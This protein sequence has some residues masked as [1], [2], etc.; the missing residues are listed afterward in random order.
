M[1]CSQFFIP[2]DSHPI[3]SVR[4]NR[5]IFTLHFGSGPLL[6]LRHDEARALLAALETGVFAVCG[7][8]LTASQARQ[9]IEALQV[10]FFPKYSN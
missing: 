6:P 5:E 7:Q 1:D 3:L 10:H 2:A 8:D 9:L 4:E